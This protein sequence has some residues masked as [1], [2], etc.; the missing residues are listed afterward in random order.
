MLRKEYRSLQI[1]FRNKYDA[2][3]TGEHVASIEI[4][5]SVCG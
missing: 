2:V 1:I 4:L 5:L 3:Q